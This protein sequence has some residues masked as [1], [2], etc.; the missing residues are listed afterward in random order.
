MTDVI[1]SRLR[2]APRHA[3][4]SSA[5]DL[6]LSMAACVLIAIASYIIVIN[7]SLELIEVAGETMWIRL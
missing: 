7:L 2:M 5:Q 3:S 6:T 4:W 1:A